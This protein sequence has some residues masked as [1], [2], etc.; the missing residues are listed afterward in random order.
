[1]APPTSPPRYIGHTIRPRSTP[2]R[3]GL[4]RAFSPTAI[5]AARPSRPPPSRPTPASIAGTARG[6]RATGNGW[7]TN[8]PD[9]HHGI[10]ATERRQLRRSARQRTT[11]YTLRS[12]YIGKTIR[13]ACAPHHPAP[14]RRAWPDAVV[15]AAARPRTP[16]CRRFGHAPRGRSPA[17]TA[18]D[19]RADLVRRCLVPLRPQR[20]QLPAIGGARS[21]PTG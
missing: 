12:D 15:R 9:L 10:A 17:P 11:T 20:Q 21:S 8:R 4:T 5:V 16:C 19:A 3:G 14:T 2:E 1:M 6:E 7:W 18:A 13:S